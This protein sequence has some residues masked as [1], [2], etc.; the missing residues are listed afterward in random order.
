[1]SVISEDKWDEI[2]RDVQKHVAELKSLKRDNNINAHSFI[3]SKIRTYF[4]ELKKENPELSL[5]SEDHLDFLT[6]NLFN[7]VWPEEEEEKDPYGY[8]YGGRSKRR[9]SKRRI[10]SKRRRKSR[11]SNRK[12]IKSKKITK[13]LSKRRTRK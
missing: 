6:G 4:D 1:M 9:K 13:K 10:K 2:K 8:M 11:I 12:T 5:P 3:K 7:H